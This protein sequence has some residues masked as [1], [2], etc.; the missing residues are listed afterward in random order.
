MEIQWDV[1]EWRERENPV[2]CVAGSTRRQMI[3]EEKKTRLSMVG[4]DECVGAIE[5]T[6]NVTTIAKKC[7]EPTEQILNILLSKGGE[8]SKGGKKK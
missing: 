4:A 2:W 3:T 1:P 6:N 5:A 8:V 7:F